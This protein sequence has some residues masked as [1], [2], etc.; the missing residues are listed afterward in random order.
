[1]VLGAKNSI[2]R[3]ST[4][5]SKFTNLNSVADK[6]STPIIMMSV[7]KGKYRK[8]VTKSFPS[9]K[10]MKDARPK[11]IKSGQKRVTRQSK[12]K[13]GKGN[14]MKTDGGSQRPHFHDSNHN[15]KK[16]PNI[17]YRKKSKEKT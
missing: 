8:N 9:R 3:N 6:I 15:N 1:M 12:N 5:C 13:S 11:P 2:G 14:K 17:H 10:R 7:T 16:K 4:K